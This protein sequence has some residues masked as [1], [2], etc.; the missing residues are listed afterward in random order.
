MNRQAQPEPSA[1][2]QALANDRSHS[3]LPQNV[4]ND[5]YV[6][7][8]AYNEAASIEQVV[9]GVRPIYP[10]V[11]VVDDGSVD[12]TFVAAK[13]AGALA[14]RHVI[15][16][17]QGAALQTGIEF[18]I[19]QGAR[20]VVTFDADGQHEVDDIKAMVEPILRGDCEVT[21]G[22]R[23]LGQAHNLPASRRRLL[24]LAVLFTRLMNGLKLTDA[25]NGLRCFSRAAAQK[26]DIHLDGM[27]HASEIIDFI[28]RGRL[29]YQEVPVHI[30]Y[31]EYSLAKGQSSRGA[32]KIAL[33]YLIDRVIR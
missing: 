29:P 23:F 5:T 7:I 15:N 31:T 8:P 17:G 30:H 13:A 16:R 21:L 26:M 24:R 27:A 18:A 3:V 11:V 33:H 9:R 22:S 32:A 20:F 1:E 14:L 6:V 25:H 2:A 19:A 4:R 12:Q 28:G 10:H